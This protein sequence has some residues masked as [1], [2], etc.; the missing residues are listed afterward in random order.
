MD[1]PKTLKQLLKEHRKNRDYLWQKL[2][3]RIGWFERVAE[4]DGNPF[5]RSLIREIHDYV[6]LES[7]F[8]S[9][10]TKRYSEEQPSSERRYSPYERTAEPI[11]QRLADG[12]DR[13]IFKLN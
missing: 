1:K 3:I 6:T 10:N 13:T 4:A 8:K 11:A 9:L 12:L 7:L 2:L 5:I